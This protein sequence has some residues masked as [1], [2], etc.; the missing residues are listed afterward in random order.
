MLNLILK[1]LFLTIPAISTNVAAQT[2]DSILE[3][4]LYDYAGSAGATATVSP[5]EIDDQPFS[6]GYRISV[7]GTSARI[8]DSY[9][10][11]STTKNINFGDNLRLTLWIRK[12]AP[13]NNH[14]IRV[15]VSFE[16]KTTPLKRSLLTALPCNRADWAKY[17]IKFKSDG[18][19]PAGEAQVMLQF[20][21]GPQTF[22]IAGITAVNLG[23]TPALTTSGIPVLT[24]NIYQNYVSYIDQTVGGS[25][26]P[27]SV[28]GPG[29]GQAFRIMINGNSE[30]VYRSG[31][32]FNNATA[33]NKDDLMLLTFW[34]RKI[35]SADANII[36]AQ[37]VFERDGPH[38]EKSLN[39]NFPNDTG[40]WKQYQIPFKAR[41]N[42]TAGQ[43]RLIFQFAYGPQKFEIGGIRLSNFGREITLD[44]LPAAFYYPGREDLNAGWRVEA[45]DRINQFRKSDLTVKVR[46]RYG[47]QIPG[48]AVYVQQTGHAFRFGSA[49]TAQLVAGARENAAER[50]AYR[51]RVTSHFN[52][53]VLENDL[54]WPFW[55]DWA[56]WN[57]Q[58]TLNTLAW[59]REMGI[60]VRGHTLIWPDYGNM[61]SNTRGLG[62]TELRTRIEN[63]FAEILKPENAG[64]KCYQWDVINEPYTSFE[65]QGLINGI[66]GIKPSEGVLGNLEMVRWFEAARSLDPRARLYLNDYDILEAGGINTPHQNYYFA[67]ANWLLDRGAPLDGLGLQGHFDRITP[68]STMQ[69]IIERFSQLPL[70]LAITEFDVNLLDEQLQADYTRDVMTLVFSSPKFNDFLCWGFWEKAHWQ[71]DAAMYRSDW[72]SKPNALV[73]NDLVFNQWWTSENGVSDAAG[74]FTVRGFKGTYN[75]TVVYQR[76]SKT[77]AATIDSNGEVEVKLNLIVAGSPMRRAGGRRVAN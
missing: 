68:P 1:L 37:V 70:D 12:V 14:N 35:E 10:R 34:V 18:N 47:N 40:E 53:T 63:H 8:G 2:G 41:D 71:P 54:K 58:A 11:W 48:A 45:N 20:G 9:L 24:D 67:L 46:D 17:D 39:V 49:I 23:P 29:F 69:S 19:Y 38:F 52:V 72:S 50:A 21:H 33:I 16:N 55:E 25:I 77:V 74:S 64:G 13:L 51:S 32:Y 73:F 56:E 15:F 4:N 61:P 65:V 75:I 31:L 59:L 60:P 36:K 28:P 76:L 7:A 22:E 44:Q 43:A 3:E 57:R 62:V 27:V 42:F 6:R 30:F 26:T 66:D 5:I